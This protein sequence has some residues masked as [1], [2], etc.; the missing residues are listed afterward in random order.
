MFCEVDL[1]ENI[2]YVLV[3]AYSSSVYCALVLEMF[4]RKIEEESGEHEQ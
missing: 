2:F 3:I 4:W 1:K